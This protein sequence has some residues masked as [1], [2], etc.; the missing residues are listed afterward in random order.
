[1]EETNHDESMS[2][3]DTLVT[4]EPDKTL[5]TVVYRKP[6][7]IDQHLHWNIH[8]NLAAKY[9]VFTTLTYRTRTVC[10]NKILIQKHEKHICEAFKGAII[11]LGLLT[12]WNLKTTTNTTLTTQQKTTIGRQQI[13]GSASQ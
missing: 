4:L 10:S 5:S 13:H 6:T 7:H 2:F 8:N 12:G 1:M 3:S 9:S 11:P